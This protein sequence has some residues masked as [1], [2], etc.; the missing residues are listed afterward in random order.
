LTL[1]KAHIGLFTLISAQGKES[2]GGLEAAMRAATL[3]TQ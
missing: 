3:A 1:D 2:A